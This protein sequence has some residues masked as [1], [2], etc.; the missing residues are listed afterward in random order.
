VGFNTER[1]EDTEKRQQ[2]K[3]LGVS[4]QANFGVLQGFQRTCLEGQEMTNPRLYFFGGGK[5]GRVR[6]NLMQTETTCPFQAPRIAA[7]ASELC[8]RCLSP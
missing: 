8:C 5:D 6:L 7:A 2:E 1:T 4:G 3:R